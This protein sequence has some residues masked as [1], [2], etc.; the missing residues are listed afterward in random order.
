MYNYDL[1]NFFFLLRSSLFGVYLTVL[2][3]NEINRK[4]IKC[5]RLNLQS[6]LQISI[7]LLGM[8]L[9]WLVEYRVIAENLTGVIL[10]FICSRNHLKVGNNCAL[11]VSD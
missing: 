5:R 3:V 7:Q 2:N 9:I 1:F 4:E 11:Q 10:K 6:H 8:R